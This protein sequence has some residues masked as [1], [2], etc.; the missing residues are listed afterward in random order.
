VT[1]AQV[2]ESAGSSADLANL[3]IGC[4]AAALLRSC[5]YALSVNEHR[6]KLV[7]AAEDEGKVADVN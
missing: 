1:Y 3:K 7:L 6:V 2:Y 5:T 4:R